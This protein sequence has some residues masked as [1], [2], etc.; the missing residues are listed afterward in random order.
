MPQEQK[1]NPLHGV[2][3]EAL[4]QELVE[5]YSWEILASEINLN[6][7]KTNPSIKSSLKFLRKTE[8]A[9]EKVERFYLYDYKKLPK[10][11]KSEFDIPPRKREMSIIKKK[12]DTK[13][14]QHNKG[15]FN[16]WD[17]SSKAEK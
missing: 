1:N 4:L 16:P 15:K 3:L 17:N 6:C 11:C 9:R 2:K 10:P 12:Q 7:F 13:I 14:T 5:N 8:W